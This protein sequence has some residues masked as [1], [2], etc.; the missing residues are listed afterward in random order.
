VNLNWEGLLPISG[1]VIVVED[2]P[3][4]RLLMAEIL[5]EI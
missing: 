2:D 5:K 1:D 3:T 4:F